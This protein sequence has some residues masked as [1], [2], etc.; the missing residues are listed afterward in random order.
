MIISFPSANAFSANFRLWL[1]PGIIAQVIGTFNFRN[2][3]DT[4]SFLYPK[5]SITNTIVPDVV[6]P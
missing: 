1:C 6:L 3:S 4:E 2:P 5:S